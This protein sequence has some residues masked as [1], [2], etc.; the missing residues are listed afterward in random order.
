MA[1]GPWVA[2]P[3]TSGTVADVAR[4]GAAAADAPVAEQPPKNSDDANN[5]DAN[6][7]D[8]NNDDASAPAREGAKGQ[9]ICVSLTDV[10]AIRRGKVGG[11]AALNV[12]GEDLTVARDAPVT[13]KLGRG[14]CP[15]SPTEVTLSGR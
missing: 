1:A 2:T 13:A 12:A 3:A 8:A 4:T 11:I 5:D 10:A 9:V 15:A 6:N 7:D 14:K